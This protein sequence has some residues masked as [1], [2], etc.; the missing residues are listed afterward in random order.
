[1]NDTRCLLPAKLNGS[2]VYADNCAPQGVLANMAF[3]NSNLVKQEKQLCYGVK[4]TEE[5]NSVLISKYEANQ[6]ARV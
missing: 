2:T 1:M 4:L 5:I 6:R 3:K